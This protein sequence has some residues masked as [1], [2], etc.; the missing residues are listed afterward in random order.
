MDVKYKE[1]LDD[2]R[3]KFSAVVDVSRLLP[4]LESAETLTHS[5]VDEINK[6]AT[7]KEKVDKILDVLMKKDNHAFQSL[8]FALETTYPHLLTVM[9]LGNSQQAGTASG[10]GN[11]DLGTG[12]SV[13]MH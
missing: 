1:L 12:R 10:P 3:A 11:V 8:C 4:I 2:H 13:P 6:L 5:D 9:F 7:S